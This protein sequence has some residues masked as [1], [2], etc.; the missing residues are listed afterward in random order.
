MYVIG[1]GLMK[2]GRGRTSLYERGY[3]ALERVR[4]YDREREVSP[5]IRGVGG[6]GEGM[7]GVRERERFGMCLEHLVE[8][9]GGYFWA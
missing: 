8:A 7:R 2:R 6:L 9:L 3:V 1:L 4:D 5:C